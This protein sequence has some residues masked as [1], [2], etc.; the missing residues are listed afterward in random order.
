[1]LLSG[2]GYHCEYPEAR[3]N[4]LLTMRLLN[5]EDL[6]K[7]SLSTYHQYPSLVIINLLKSKGTKS[8]LE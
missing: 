7:P 5:Y 8:N 2:Y 4:T 3:I 1:M 6:P